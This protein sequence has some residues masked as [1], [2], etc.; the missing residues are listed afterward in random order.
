[1]HRLRRLR[2]LVKDEKDFASGSL[3]DLIEQMLNY[4]PDDRITAREALKH[5]FF[6]LG[7][8]FFSRE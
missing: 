7:E 8:D 3:C 1:M 6:Y 4:D 5:P 2:D